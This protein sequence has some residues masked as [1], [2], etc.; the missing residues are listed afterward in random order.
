M[1]IPTPHINAN[2]NDFAK[3][4]LMPGDPLRSKFI[5]EN[6]L[7]DVKLVNEVR[8]AYGYTGK[9]KGQSVSV[10]TSGMGMPSMAIYSHELFNF[11]DVENIIRVGSAGAISENLKIFDIIAASS[12]CT[13]SNFAN[14]FQI[15]GSFSPQANFD[16]LKICDCIANEKNIN[17]NIGPVFTSDHFYDFGNDA[18]SFKKFGVLGVEMET[19]AL[20]INA[21]LSGKKALS[22]LT[23]SDIPGKNVE[24]S[25]KE[26]EKGF[27]EMISLAL[28]TAILIGEK[29]D[30]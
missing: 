23:V 19:A 3:T 12:A 15:N 8:C 29:N 20:Y 13:N 6:F 5:A 30:K 22:L 7:S 27:E 10:M 1:N 21:A 17:L 4:V 9:Y 14:N 2:K 16:L 18:Q 24:I 26:R 28:E 25:S 11:Y